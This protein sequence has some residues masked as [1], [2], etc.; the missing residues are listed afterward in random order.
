MR[1]TPRTSPLEEKLD[2]A[3]GVF[4][5][6]G[7]YD[8]SIEDLMERTGLHRAAVYGAY[9]SKKKFFELLLR[10]YRVT[11]ITKFFAPL[12]TPYASL[13]QIE[14]FFRQ[15]QDLNGTPARLGCLMCLTSS[16][17]APHARSV[18]RIVSDWLDDLRSLM[19][20]ACANALKRR[21]VR[22]A[23]DPDLVA[24][25]GV[26][27]VLG[28]WAMIRSPM[29]RDAVVRYVDGVLTYLQHLRPV[30]GGER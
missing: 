25:Y 16:E 4:W 24:D 30:K 12:E 15:F 29:P 28:T 17:V 7:Y 13:A 3:M 9:G 11:Y 19:R 20:T 1:K 8:T 18:E 6:K 10:R 22:S 26:G 27:A 5:E 14:T 21:E 2:A 23:T